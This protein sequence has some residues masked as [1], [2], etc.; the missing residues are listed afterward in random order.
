[1]TRA[2]LTASL[3]LWRR[4][5]AYRRKRRAATQGTKR[6]SHY[7]ALV[8][9]ALDH[10]KK[11]KAQLAKL[12]PTKIGPRGVDLIKEFEG[13]YSRPYDDGLGFMT[14]GWG[15]LAHDF[16]NGRLP[17]SMTRAAGDKMLKRILDERYVPPVVKCAKHYGLELSQNELDALASFSFN[18]GTGAFDPSRTAGFETLHRALRSKNRQDIGQ[19]LLVYSNPGDA[20]VHAGL[21]RRRRA[22][23]ALFLKKG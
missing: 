20:N 19:A 9:D 12:A 1:M 3:A 23:R 5:L 21:L 22:E 14:I 4:R 16:P 10:V 2:F 6:H 7:D 15:F 13:W 17:S 11:R 18:L 8:L